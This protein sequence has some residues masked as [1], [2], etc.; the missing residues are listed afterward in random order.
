MMPISR[1]VFYEVV[2]RIC[3]YTNGSITSGIRSLARNVTV[4]GLAT[5]LHLH[6]RAF[7]CVFDTTSEKQRALLLCRALGFGVVDEGDHLHI[8]DRK[9]LAGKGTPDDTKTT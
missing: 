5:S 4:G 1:G 3:E 2:C 9:P 8:Q 6:G 7:D